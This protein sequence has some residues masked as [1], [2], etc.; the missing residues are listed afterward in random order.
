[1]LDEQVGVE[2]QRQLV[3]V[4]RDP[5][6]AFPQPDNVQQSRP[7]SAVVTQPADPG[8]PACGVRDLIKL[9]GWVV[10]AIAGKILLQV[11]EGDIGQVTD[12]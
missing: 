5:G 3:T 11:A 8:P 12:I 6:E 1:M 4:I 2:E 10:P 9:P 7:F